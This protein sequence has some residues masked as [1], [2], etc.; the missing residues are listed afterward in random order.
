MKK[1]LLILLC[2]LILTGCTSEQREEP[3]RPP[4]QVITESEI[5]T[6]PDNGDTALISVSVPATL[7]SYYLEDGTLLFSYIGQHMQMIHPNEELSDRIIL[8]FLNRVD[9]GIPYAETA[10]MDAQ[11]DY[12]FRS[13]WYPYFHHV[14]Y[15]PTRIDEDVLSLSG[16][17]NYYTGGMHGNLSVVAANYDMQ[18]GDVL[19]WGSI[20]H[21][22]AE[23]DDFIQII[24]QKL[25]DMED[26]YLLYEDY[27]SVVQDRFNVDENFFEDFYF[28]D[29]G[30]VFYFSPYEIAPYASGIITIE[31]PYHELTGFIHDG[32]FPPEREQIQGKLDYAS[33]NKINTDQFSNMTEVILTADEEPVF[34]YPAGTVEDIRI[35]VS[36]DGKNIPDYT[37]FASPRLSDGDAIILQATQ[38][39]L[40]NLIVR[41]YS[42]ESTELLD[43][44]E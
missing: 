32:Y 29:T 34:I 43:F 4:V 1:I 10:Y 9:A 25:A 2:T 35:V 38:S 27:E 44:S 19:T 5:E 40:Q 14:L 23:A 24:S 11:T 37:V 16:I 8:D 30:L 42:G 41:Y 3:T 21:E 28:T 18:T 7:D 26:E 36:G 15:S 33:V 13:D 31:I 20:M 39:E 6:S 22:N 17:Q 12:E